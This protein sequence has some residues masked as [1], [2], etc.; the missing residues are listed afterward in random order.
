MRQVVVGYGESRLV[1]ECTAWFGTAGMD[2]CGQLWY[3]E[4]SLVLASYGRHGK[5]R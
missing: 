1:G 4:V 2:R 5:D 3:G